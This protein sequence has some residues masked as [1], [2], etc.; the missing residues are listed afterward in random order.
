M[1]ILSSPLLPSLCPGG[2]CDTRCWG[3]GGVL[4]QAYKQPFSSMPRSTIHLQV[5]LEPWCLQ[6]QS[7][8]N[9][10]PPLP[11]PHCHDYKQRPCATHSLVFSLFCKG[12]ECEDIVKVC[13]VFCVFV[14]KNPFD[15]N[16]EPLNT[17]LTFQHFVSSSPEMFGFVF[18]CCSHSVPL[19][20]TVDWILSKTG[21][22]G[23]ANTY[24]R[25]T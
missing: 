7:V 19:L 20:L 1:V 15:P 17:Q 14:F 13:V 16:E 25:I 3:P 2:V 11:P 18:W 21:F 23:H 8:P 12:L 6:S 9:K 4:I 10:A 22:L 24:L 5:V